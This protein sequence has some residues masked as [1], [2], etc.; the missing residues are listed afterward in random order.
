MSK[1]IG[2]KDFDLARRSD[3]KCNT[4]KL[5]SRTA[6]EINMKILVW[7][8]LVMSLERDS[9]GQRHKGIDCFYD[10]SSSFFVC[11]TTQKNS[12]NP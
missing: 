8:V 5:V 11:Y 6:R 9:A 12:C 2:E 3:G 10:S 1:V 4:S 7:L